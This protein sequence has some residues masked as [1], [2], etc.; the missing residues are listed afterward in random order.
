M[1][2]SLSM[3]QLSTGGMI[4]RLLLLTCVCCVG[5][6]RSWHAD[7]RN[8][9][10]RRNGMWRRSAVRGNDRNCASAMN[11][12]AA[13]TTVLLN[14]PSDASALLFSYCCRRFSGRQQAVREADA[15]GGCV[16]TLL[17]AA[18]S[19]PVGTPRYDLMK[20]RGLS[21][22][23]GSSK[24]RSNT[25]D[26]GWGGAD[27]AGAT[28]GERIDYAG[29]LEVYLEAFLLGHVRRVTKASRH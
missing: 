29:L 27:Q 25:A 2:L 24:Q 26:H 11:D 20:S 21:G 1:Q 19:L 12:S 7:W 28:F 22:N 3:L 15:G 17:V 18:S 14:H 9:M 13:L 10:R 4:I 23:T 6:G 16:Y 5:A 8:G